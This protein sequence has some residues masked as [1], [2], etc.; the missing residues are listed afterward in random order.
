ML[1]EEI[2][3]EVNVP[4]E[5]SIY[6]GHVMIAGWAISTQEKNVSILAYVNNSLK[7]TLKTSQRTPYVRQAYP[8]L[9]PGLNTAFWGMI[10]LNDV[11]DGIH[12]L[13][14]VAKTDTSEKVLKN[15][16]INLQKQDLSSFSKYDE[17]FVNAAKNSDDIIGRKL[18]KYFIEWIKLKPN[19]RVFDVGCG[20]G[21]MAKL[22]SNYLNRSGRYDG[23]DVMPEAIDWC[24]KII[25]SSKFSNFHFTLAPLFNE[26]YNPSGTGKGSEYKFPF[27]DQSFDFVFLISV[28]T[29]L[30]P[31][32][33]ENYL[34]E[35]SRVL[36]KDGRCFI[37]YFLLIDDS[38]K[39]ME[40]TNEFN[41]KYQFDGFRSV[42]NVV[43]EAAIA[44]EESNIREL[45]KKNGL[46]IIEPV[47][48]G[49]WCGRQ[50]FSQ[51]VGQDV[52]LAVKTNCS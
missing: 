13:R 33:L 10:D 51:G 5:T 48:Y 24:S 11:E 4:D 47:R 46:S 32:D 8:K 34:S 26:N 15:I 1:L 16:N 28:F 18:M 27:E 42:F 37:T 17:N 29:H 35:I 7:G 2:I 31:Q 6:H 12:N 40:G 14:I 25:P 3:G 21:R 52:I 20:Y 39:L 45:Y 44:Y 50:N 38:V 36:K 49:N 30:F 19:E 23:L 43:P 41:F 9:S 22:L